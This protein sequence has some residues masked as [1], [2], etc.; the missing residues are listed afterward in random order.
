MSSHAEDPGP[1]GFLQIAEAARLLGVSAS[2]LRNW[3]RSGKLKARRHPLN[4][5]RVYSRTDLRAIQIG[6]EGR[7]ALSSRF[8]W[9][10]LGEREHVVQFYE[11]EGCLADSVA[12]FAAQ[13][14]SSGG[15][16]LLIATSRHRKRIEG[17]LRARGCDSSAAFSRGRYVALD[18]GATLRAIMEGGRPD[19]GRFAQL[20]G[21]AV[22]DMIGSCRGVRAFGEMVALLWRAGNREAAIRLEGL[23]NELAKDHAF[24]L[25]CAYPL[26]LFSASGDAEPFHEVCCSHTKVVP[27][28]SFGLLQTADARLR[29]IS[30]LQQKAKALEKEI[31]SRRQAE[32]ELADFVGNA[33]EGFLKLGPDG[34]ILWANRAE[35]QMLGYEE[36]EYVGHHVSEF[37]AGRGSAEHILAVVS[38]GGE[39]LNYRAELLRKDGTPCHVLIHANGRHDRGKLRFIRCF[40]RD[41]TGTRKAERD[42]AWLAAIVGSSDDA[43]IGKDPAGIITSWNKAAERLFGYTAEEA[44]GRPVAMLIPGDRAAEEPGILARI[45]RGERVEHYETV[46]RRKDGSLVEVSLSVSPVF[47]GRGHLVGASKIARDITGRKEA[48]NRHRL[49]EERYRHL[50]ELMPVGVYTCDTAG[51]ITYFNRHAELLWGRA[52]RTGGDGERYCGSLKLWR[53]SGGPLPHAECPM[54]VAVRQGISFENQEVV[55]E[56]PDG[57][58]I[59]VLANIA[60]LRDESGGIAGAINAFLDMTPLKEA[61]AA[62]RE[63]ARKK[64]EFLATMAHELRNPLAPVRHCLELLRLSENAGPGLREIHLVIERQVGHM[65]RLV[66][67][68]LEVSRINRGTI[69]LRNER[70]AME[71]VMAQALEASKP[72]Y[73]STGHRA[74]VSYAGSPVLVEGDPV[75]LVQVFVNLLNNAAKFSEDGSIVEVRVGRDA[76]GACISIK[77]AGI[78][79]EPEMIP[80]L[81]GMFVRMPGSTGRPP[82]GLGIGLHLVKTLVELHG[83]SV[84]ARSEGLGRG[85][86]F[87]VRLPEALEKRGDPG[88]PAE[89]LPATGGDP[90]ARRR[91]VVVDDNKDAADGL[92]LLLGWINADVRVAYDGRSA[93]EAVRAFRPSVV[94]LDIGLPDLSG[95]EVA[96]RLRSDPANGPLMI[97]ALSG[98]GRAED[99]RRSEEA[100]I[101]HHLVKPAAFGELRALLDTAAANGAALPRTDFAT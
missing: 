65:V 60:P 13:A 8:D 63:E 4:G 35:L 46:R 41:M 43:I 17:E 75:R 67:D 36:E 47:D 12:R 71:T 9:E 21:G 3:D 30:V 5:Y 96:R 38:G 2:T 59:N 89:P 19:A 62:L 33:L 18:A 69:E 51:R 53:P 55:V 45:N 87:I 15:G 40:T 84:E 16:F 7:G 77:D 58:R 22:A 10:S 6:A 39:V 49:S 1:P 66:D 26:K 50:A 85:S 86:E 91:I 57:S 81:F 98:W 100:G 101:D 34:T 99:K 92:A 73:A 25:L 56:R 76:A 95:H 94:V 70:V 97:V 24:S 14:L 78:G 93:I 23:W 79:I 80:R 90:G 54:A 82:D 72:L 32:D 61:E 37:H 29:E 83:G 11:N 68:L 44:V 48:E 28:E 74:C 52:P 42:Q 20:V 27:A 88:R 31:E 64:D